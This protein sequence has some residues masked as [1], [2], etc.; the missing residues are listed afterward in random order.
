[1]LLENYWSKY[2]F[3]NAIKMILAQE[4]NMRQNK[5]MYCGLSESLYGTSVIYIL[6]IMSW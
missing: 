4:V 1:M 3:T 2:V 5:Y 6:P